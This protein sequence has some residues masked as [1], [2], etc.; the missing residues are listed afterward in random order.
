MMIRLAIVAT[1]LSALLFFIWS[2]T[3]LALTT[4]RYCVVLFEVPFTGKS[5][6]LPYWM[7]GPYPTL[8]LGISFV[9]AVGLWIAL[10]IKRFRIHKPAK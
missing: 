2:N 4:G 3:Y 5:Y 9:S 10:G 6:H 7:W 8:V 1:C